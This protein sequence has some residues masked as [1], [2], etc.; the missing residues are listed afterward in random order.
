[1]DRGLGSAGPV[2]PAPASGSGVLAFTGVE[3]RVLAG[4]GIALGAAIL[5]EVC[6]PL[7]GFVVRVLGTL[8][9]E[10]G[11]AAMGLLLGRPSLPSF[12]LTNGGGVTY[13]SD[14]SAGLM[15]IYGAVLAWFAW[16]RR[17]NRLAV[18]LLAGFGLA[19]GLLAFSDTWSHL[20]VVAAGNWGRLLL[21]GIFLFRALTGVAVAHAAERWLYAGIG[22]LT[23][24][25]AECEAWELM[26]PGDAQERYLAGK[27][28]VDND[29]VIL[30]EERGT[31]LEW[32]A[33]WHIVLGGVIPVAVWALW[34][35]RAACGT[36][37][38][39]ALGPGP[40]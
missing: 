30:A 10:M 26:G 40:E 2:A 19:W 34:R 38:R 29:W 15:L 16:T 23:L 28:G 13:V 37:C 9:H 35:W 12:D 4:M 36:L 8:A 11:H 20:A 24:V 33:G 1:M 27:A 6:M 39:R 22:W 31:S 7:A 25:Q 3:P 17:A 14:R 18:G 32:V 21:A 5:V